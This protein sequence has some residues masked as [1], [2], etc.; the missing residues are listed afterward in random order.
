MPQVVSTAQPTTTVWSTR[1]HVLCHV[2]NSHSCND[3]LHHQH[4]ISYN[5]SSEASSSHL[6]NYLLYIK[7]N[8]FSSY[9]TYLYHRF[10]FFLRIRPP[11]K[12]TLFPS[13][14]LFR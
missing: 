12:S 7:L 2:F 5:L 13:P 3:D 6:V 11:P 1:R 10:F 14:T 4:T 8:D 9:F